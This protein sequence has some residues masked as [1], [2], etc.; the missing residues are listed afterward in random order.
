[1][2]AS[3]HSATRAPAG[4]VSIVDHDEADA[5]RIAGL[6]ARLGGLLARREVDLGPA[7]RKWERQGEGG[8]PLRTV[9]VQTQSGGEEGC[10]V[11]YFEVAPG[12]V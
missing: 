6:L 10:D 5:R 7:L 1:M 11:G 2:A 8:R 12:T 3:P 4:V 9:A